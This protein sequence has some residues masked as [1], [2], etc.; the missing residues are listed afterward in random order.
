MRRNLAGLAIGG[1]FPCILA[2]AAGAQEADLRAG[3]F[4]YGPQQ[5]ECTGSFVDNVL[6]L[7]D[8]IPGAS[9]PTK[10]GYC[11]TYTRQVFTGTRIAPASATE[12]AKWNGMGGSGELMA[13]AVIC[14]LRELSPQL[15]GAVRIESPPI[16][17]GIG[18]VKA[19]QEIGF[20]EFRRINPEWKGYRKI[21]LELPVVGKAEAITQALTVTKHSYASFGGPLLAGNRPVT[22][23][24]ALN[25]TADDKQRL[26]I[27]KPP[28]FTVATPIGA[29]EVN[30]EFSY[31]TRT[32]VI[33][34]P[35]QALRLDMP[36]FLGSKDTVKFK[37]IY[38][39]DAGIAETTKKVFIGNFAENRTG[40]LSQLGMGTRGIH[41]DKAV[42]KDPALRPDQDP[43]KSRSGLEA[44]PSI[45]ALAAATLKYPSNPKDLLPS[46]VFGL[47]GVK[48]DA[49]ITVTPKVEA[50]VAGQLSLGSGE[51]SNYYQPK[52]FEFSATRRAAS[53][54]V[55]G[56]RTA[57]SFSVVVRLYINVS[58][59]FDFIAGKVRKT[60]IN[61]NKTF[62]VPLAGSAKT[63]KVYQGGTV[64][65]GGEFPETLDGVTTLHGI[66]HPGAQGAAA[67]IKQCYAPSQ[68]PTNE[69]KSEPATAGNPKDLFT[70]ILWP[71]N[72]CVASAAVF[73]GSTMKAP[74][75]ADTMMPSNPPPGPAPGHWKCDDYRKSGCM[76]LCTFNPATKAFA[77]AQLPKQI[78]ASLLAN[79]PNKVLFGQ[80]CDASYGVR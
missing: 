21:I 80:I 57:A 31:V 3:K 76:D 23:S 78:A 11:R 75:H 66:Q 47:P 41:S 7:C 33:A 14:S 34:S 67:F 5:P 54:L 6:K 1:I 53:S 49:Y 62:P 65:T 20:R 50:S 52:E 63:G 13:D 56:M 68:P 74:A 69:P 45:Y 72:I 43:Y 4:V 12:K 58:A 19:V 51:G 64:S 10:S 40:W 46:W 59:E 2:V 27:I 28:S 42:W 35:Y 24:Y 73:D 70:G 61:V 32:W 25:V 79:D 8:L 38:G 18:N 48:F 26:L 77:I 16:S 9:C 36:N 60:L 29:F 71:C 37:D 39:I 44:E 55:A 30:P 15:R 22:H 17:L